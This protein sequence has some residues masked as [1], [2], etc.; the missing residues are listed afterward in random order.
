MYKGYFAW[1]SGILR[2]LDNTEM[3]LEPT[4]GVKAIGRCTF[5]KLVQQITKSQRKRKT[6]VDYVL[7][8]LVYDN[9]ALVRRVI[10]DIISEKN[11]RASLFATLNASEQHAK[12]SYITG[13]LGKG[14]NAFHDLKFGLD[15]TSRSAHARESSCAQCLAPFQIF[16]EAKNACLEDI[17]DGTDEQDITRV[18][19]QAQKMLLLFYGHQQ[20][21]RKQQSR[22]AEVFDEIKAERSPLPV[23]VLVLI[24]YKMKFESIRYR[25]KSVEFFGKRGSSWHGAVIFYSDGKGAMQNLFFDH[26]SAVNLFAMQFFIINFKK[27]YMRGKCSQRPGECGKWHFLPFPENICDVCEMFATFIFWISPHQSL[28]YLPAALSF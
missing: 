1:T 13:H 6:A 18:F 9:L 16:E 17:P 4:E 25:E 28:Q 3:E 21:G 26:I 12:F 24:D 10:S 23:R 5:V 2:E 15:P 22:I 20:R 14:N 7:G 19:M 11:L 8:T 27:K